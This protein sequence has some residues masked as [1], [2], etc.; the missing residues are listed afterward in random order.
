[1]VLLY[2]DIFSIGGLLN[3]P[4]LIYYKFEVSELLLT[5]AMHFMHSHEYITNSV[6]DSSDMKGILVCTLHICDMPWLGV[7][8]ENARPINLSTIWPLCPIHA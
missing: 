5:G 7:E 6:E 1:M 2:A 8:R 3:N 4:I